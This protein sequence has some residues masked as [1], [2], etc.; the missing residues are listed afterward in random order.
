MRGARTKEFKHK[1]VTPAFRVV[2]R[3][4]IVE[5]QVANAQ[6]QNQYDCRVFRLEPHNHL[7]PRIRFCNTQRVSYHDAGKEG[8]DRDRHS[9]NRK[10]AT[11]DE[12]EKQQH[13]KYSPL[14]GC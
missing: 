14:D 10:A 2:Q 1:K 8:D 4:P 9:Y 13:E 3:P 7:F 6:D 5:Q 11:T 12:C